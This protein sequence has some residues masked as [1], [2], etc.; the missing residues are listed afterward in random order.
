MMLA[1]SASAAAQEQAAGAPSGQSPTDKQQEGRDRP[2][3]PAPPLFPKH[4]RG[5]YRNAGGE[6]VIDATPQSPPLDTD[7][8]GVPDKGEYE[9]NF[10]TQAD[11]AKQA[12]RV[13]LLL[14]DA[15]YGI[16]PGIA[17]HK[18]P[19]QVKFEF[20]LTAARKSDEPFTVG[21]GPDTFGLKFNFYH[22]EDRGISV[23]VYPQLEFGAPGGRSVQR[24]LGEN[25]QTLILPL[26]VAREFR[27]FTLTFNGALSKPIHD[28]ERNIISECGAGIGRAFTR[29]VAAMIEL[30]S[31]SSLDFKSDR[32]LFF[33]AGLIHGVRNVIVYAN[34]GHSL[35]SDDGFG[36]TYAGGGMKVLIEP[37]RKTAVH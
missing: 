35:F 1:M 14:V 16:L 18:L 2:K 34:L 8:P 7:D 21:P 4:R 29:K 5:L 3:A 15:N 26:L 19:M 20:P 10:T 11:Y 13:D 36:H 25:G 32:L 28:P 17:G 12:N 24:G 22:D 6:E 23:S 9:I 27:H 37:K 33:N 31:E 30:R